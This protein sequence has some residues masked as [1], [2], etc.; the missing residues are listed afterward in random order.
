M[1]KRA[2]Q[3]ASQHMSQA[4]RREVKAAD[5]PLLAPMRDHHRERLEFW[6]QRLEELEQGTL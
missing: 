1:E 4:V 6:S 5:L 3:E 2:L